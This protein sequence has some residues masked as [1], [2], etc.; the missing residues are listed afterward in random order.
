MVNEGTVN[1]KQETTH[2]VDIAEGGKE[3]PQSFLGDQGGQP[4]DKDCRIVRV[5]GR[6][7]FAVWSNKIAQYRAGLC[8]MLP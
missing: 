5:C 8:L 2:V 7:L 1:A 6:E 3:R 4:T